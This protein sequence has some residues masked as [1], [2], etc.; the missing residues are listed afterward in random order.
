MLCCWRFNR[1]RFRGLDRY[2][3]IYDWYET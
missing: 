1:W 2:G 3:V